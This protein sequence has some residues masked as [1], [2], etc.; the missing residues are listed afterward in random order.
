MLGRGDDEAS[1]E[2]GCCQ[3][4][5]V[6]LGKGNGASWMRSVICFRC[7]VVTSACLG[8]DYVLL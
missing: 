3:A 5:R 8:G 4:L 1:D 6:G 7:N 2:V